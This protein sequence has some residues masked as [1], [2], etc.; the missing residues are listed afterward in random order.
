MH[1]IGGNGFCGTSRTML[2]KILGRR[3]HSLGIDIKYGSEADP[4]KP[5]IRGADL[6]VAADGINSRTREAFKDQFKPTIELR[7]NHFAWMGST[8]PLDAFN[9]FFRETEHG[10]FIA[11]C[12]QYQPGRST[13]MIETDPGDVQAR[14]P[15]Q[16]RRGRL[17]RRHGKRVRR[18]ARRPQADHQPL[19]LAQLPDHPLRALDHRQHRADRRRQ[20]DRAFLDRLGHQA[21]DGGRDRA[22][23]GVPRDR[24]PR[25]EGRAGAFRIAAPRRGGED[26]ALRRRVAGLV[27]ARE[28]VLEHGPDALRLRPDDA[29]A[30]HHLRQPR[31]AR[32]GVRRRSR[33]DGGARRAGAG[34]RRPTPP[35]RWRRCSSRSGCAT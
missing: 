28:A 31:A 30:R 7:P 25:R 16:A 3:A 2:L 22:L 9:F 24:R 26:A 1:R 13:W 35:S 11:H 33:Q 14:R 5:T 10:I 20:G 8:K 12:Y 4:T 27:R 21:R 19:D 18:G 29:L 15:R 6:V 23:R 17:R 32:A 34:L